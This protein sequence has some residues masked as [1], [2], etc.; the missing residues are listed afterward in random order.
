LILHTSE[1]FI[2][3]YRNNLFLVLFLSKVEDSNWREAGEQDS[4]DDEDDN[5]ESVGDKAHAL[6]HSDDDG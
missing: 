3:L 4:D 5:D 1:F 6:D 2:F